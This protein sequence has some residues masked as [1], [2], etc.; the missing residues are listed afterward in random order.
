[1]ADPSESSTN[2]ATE[3]SETATSD[4][5]GLS[6]RLFEQGSYEISFNPDAYDPNLASG[7]MPAHQDSGSA[8]IQE[9]GVAGFTL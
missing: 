9:P 6:E 8:M 1:M 2:V 7:S 5:A 3:P 4:L